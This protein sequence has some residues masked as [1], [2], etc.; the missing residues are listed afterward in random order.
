MFVYLSFLCMY[1]RRDQVLCSSN[2][3]TSKDYSIPMWML[4]KCWFDFSS[5][6]Y[7]QCVTQ[8]LYYVKT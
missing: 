6:Y 2:F 3:I 1:V 4:S 5:F 8:G 7:R